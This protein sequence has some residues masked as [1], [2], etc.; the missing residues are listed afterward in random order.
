MI[1]TARYRK[2]TAQ[3][4]PTPITALNQ[5]LLEEITAQDLRD[6]VSIIGVYISRPAATLIDFYDVDTVEVLRGPQGTTIGKNSRSGGVAMNTIRP[7]GSL[8]DGVEVNAGNYGRM[9]YRGAV[10]FPIIFASPHFNRT[11][12]LDDGAFDVGR[13]VLDFYNTDQN[14]LTAILNW[15]IGDL[16][17]ILGLF[18]FEEEHEIVQSFPTL[19]NPSS[20]DYSRQVGDSLAI[21]P[22]SLFG[23][24]DSDRTTVRSTRCRYRYRVH[25]TSSHG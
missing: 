16:E 24:L 1:V 12:E 19:G 4:A 13:E 7:D 14:T 3:D 11:G 20:A 22:Q 15:D 25:T 23:D 18:Y 9:D 5:T 8:D 17:V 2:E 10:Q 21:L 6:G